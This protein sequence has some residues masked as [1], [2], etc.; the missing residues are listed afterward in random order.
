MIPAAPA[1][2]GPPDNTEGVDGMAQTSSLGRWPRG[3]RWLARLCC[4]VGGV[5][6]LA[7]APLPHF[8]KALT[9]GPAAEWRFWDLQHGS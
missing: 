6:L 5:G 7:A 4:M 2:G 8:A 3:R 1:A 9:L